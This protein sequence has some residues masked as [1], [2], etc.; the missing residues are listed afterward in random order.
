M[1]PGNGSETALLAKTS[2]RLARP[3][4]FPASMTAFLKIDDCNCCHRSLPWEWVPAVLLN[5]KT[6]AGTA[7]WQSQLIDGRC[8]ACCAAMALERRKE[9]HARAMRQELIQL[10][11]GEKPYREF[12]FDR[13]QV[14]PGNR[15]AFESATRFNP[16]N[17]TLYLW[18]SCGV[19]KTH[20][21][22]A[23]ARRWS[24]QAR[25]VEIFRPPQLSRKLRMK[26]PLEEQ[27]ITDQLIRADVFVLDDLGMG[28]DTPFSRQV[29]QEILD[30]REFT[31][32][33]GLVITSKYSLDGLAEKLGDDAIPSRLAGMC[34]V[35][36]IQGADRRLTIRRETL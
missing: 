16:S 5:G 30:G 7:V 14:A 34:S 29:L 12:T 18:G 33:S 27:A 19:G 11:G 26:E 22:Y 24:E 20:L 2:T 6:L 32:R 31:D 10:L 21:A 17:D 8:P 15:L 1:S 4:R 13:F 36:Q 3:D 9:Q 23:I 25:T 28:T 35:V